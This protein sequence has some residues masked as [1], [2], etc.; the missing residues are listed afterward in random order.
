MTVR[1]LIKKPPVPTKRAI[2]IL[3]KVQSCSALL[4]VLVVFMR[5]CR[6]SVLRYTFL[7]LD[8]RRLDALYLCEQG[9][10]DP[11]LFFETKRGRLAKTFVK[12]CSK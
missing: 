5:S 2:V 8:T 1:V 9:C 4:R 11:R 10:E 6:K 3:S 12:N 7:M